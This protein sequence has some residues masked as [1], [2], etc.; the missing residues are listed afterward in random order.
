MNQLKPIKDKIVVIEKEREGKSKGGIIVR[1]TS[2]SLGSKVGV[3]VAVGP[4]VTSVKTGDEIY[5]EWH[6]GVLFQIEEKIH[7]VIHEDEVLAIIT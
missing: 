4:D 5:L 1:D 3:V 6:K 7:I 2:L